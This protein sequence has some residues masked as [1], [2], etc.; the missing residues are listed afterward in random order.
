MDIVWRLG[1]SACANVTRQRLQKSTLLPSFYLN[2]DKMFNFRSWFKHG[3]NVSGSNKSLFPASW[4]GGG[5]LIG[6][7]GCLGLL[8]GHPWSIGPHHSDHLVST[9]Q[10]HTY[11]RH[12]S[13]TFPS[14]LIIIPS[15]SD[16]MLADITA[17]I[18]PGIFTIHKTAGY[19]LLTSIYGR[20][21]FVPSLDDYKVY[22]NDL[23][24]N[25][26][27]WPQLCEQP[28]DMD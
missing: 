20:K 10:C 14:F 2:P 1:M 4:V 12:K 18:W 21:W 9:S 8:A 13:S 26:S 25:I 28:S 6:E 27:F 15:W 22:R 5:E 16:L 7:C 24:R 23:N 3:Q 17:H 11:R 19:L